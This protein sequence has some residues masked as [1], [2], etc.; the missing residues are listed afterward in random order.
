MQSILANIAMKCSMNLISN[1][2]C[3]IKCRGVKLNRV[4]KKNP[5]V[6][7]ALLK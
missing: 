7:R 6:W 3:E 4:K 1:V 2:H 5:A